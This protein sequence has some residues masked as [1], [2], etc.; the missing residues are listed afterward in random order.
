M[1]EPY[2]RWQAEAIAAALN[3]RRVVLLDGP[4]QCGKTTLAKAIAKT[5][6]AVDYRTL[7]DQTLLNA[8]IDDPHGFVAHGDNLM[9]IDEVQRAPMLLTAIKKDVDENQKPGRFI[10]T[11]SANIQSLPKVRESLAGRVRRIRLRPLCEGELART[12]PRFLEHAFSGDY[13]TF[14]ISRLTK[15]D[16]LCM[17]LRG[18]YPEAIRL[19]SG[20][21]QQMWHK[22]YL[23]A[24]IERD[25]RD[26]ANIR[27]RDSLWKLIEALA[28][29][30]SKYMDI[31][32]IGAALSLTH[33]TLD[34]YINAIET[35]YLVDRIRPWTKTDYA[36]VGKKDKLFM[37]DT[38]LMAACMGWTLDQVRLDGERN[39]K[40]MESFVYMQLAALIDTSEGHYE[41]SHYRDREQRE[42]DFLIEA[43]NGAIIGI[44]VKSGTNI[45]SDS[46]KHLRWFKTHIAPNQAFTGIVLYSGERVVSF[47]EHMWALP[48]SSLW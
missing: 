20:Q 18:G 34:S 13:R 8:A 46:F 38:G 15:D 30:S 7:D 41:L 36:R 47:G 40:L 25:L 2:P 33:G 9:I 44:E 6:R 3:T 43:A 16:Y 5:G 32:A 11:G 19:N 10:L 22:D 29:W 23:D 28:A 4:R 31:S 1:Q 27:R 17:A 26:I 48:I 45:S 21:Q 14:P 35:L 24:L 42:I 12:E 39:G 37:A